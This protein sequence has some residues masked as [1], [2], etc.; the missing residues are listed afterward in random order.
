MQNKLYYTAMEV[1]NLLG[2][3]RAKGYQICRE[4]NEELAKQGYIVIAGK[5]PKKYL[6]EK[7]YGFAD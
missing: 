3:S 1:A 7:Y 4:M 2:V 6:E 5:I